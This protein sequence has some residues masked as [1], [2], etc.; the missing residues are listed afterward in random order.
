LTAIVRH[1]RFAMWERRAIRE[2]CASGARVPIGK[3]ALAGA[4]GDCR[5][6]FL[7]HRLILSSLGLVVRECRLTAS[8]AM[9]KTDFLSHN[10]RF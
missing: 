9:G 1:W 5:P 7:G 3:E 4:A 8:A 2:R 10:D 6:G